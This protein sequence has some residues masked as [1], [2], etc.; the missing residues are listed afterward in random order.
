MCIIIL[1][2]S[3]SLVSSKVEWA[4]N[5]YSDCIAILNAYKAWCSMKDEK[6]FHSH[7]DRKVKKS[8]QV[9]L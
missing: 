9:M 5:S 3:L 1:S 4:E 7:N 8:A 6:A 2:L